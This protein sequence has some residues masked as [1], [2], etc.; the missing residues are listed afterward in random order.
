MTA[1]ALFVTGTDTGVGKTRISVALLRAARELGI[2]A[3]GYK[4]VA[5]GCERIDGRLSNEDARALLAESADGL[6]YEDINPVALEL[7]IAPHIAAQRAGTVINAARLDHGL[8][9]LRERVELVIVEGA[10]GW[11]V[12]LAPSLGF[13]DWC[14]R[15]EL[16][17]LMVVGLRLGCLNHALLTAEAVG[18]ERLAGWVA[19]RL[20]P[21]MPEVEANIEALH[22][23]LSAPCAAQV[24]VDDPPDRSARA[25]SAWLQTLV[26]GGGTTARTEP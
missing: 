23:R 26:S 4:P 3:A 17:V 18:A 6:T 19:N 14:R 10:G 9:R 25:L 12:P 11:R 5:A 2:R 8:A 24:P 16:P 21:E 15:Q 20:P 13:D 1:T 7:P 22:E